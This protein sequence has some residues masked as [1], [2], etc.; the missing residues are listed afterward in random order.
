MSLLKKHWLLLTLLAIGIFVRTYDFGNI[1]PGL[2]QDEASTG[3]DAFA[4]LHFG[5]DRNG[6]ANPVMLVSWGSGMYP[7]PIYLL[8]PI[9]ALFGT[10]VFTLRLLQLLG[11]IATLLLFYDFLRRNETLYF[12]LLAL[13]LLVISPW[14]IMMSRWALDSNLL[15]FTFLAGTYCI[16]RAKQHSGWLIIASIIFALTFY[17]YGTAYVITPLFL[18]LISPYVIFSVHHK[19]KIFAISLAVFLIIA[20]PIIYYVLCNQFNLPEI[21]T[22][23]FSIPRLPG[24]ARF[25]TVSSLFHGNALR[26]IGNNF[27]NT[28]HLLINGSDGL[29]WNSFGAYGY[30]YTPA[31]FL[32]V[33]GV[34]VVLIR[35]Q[36]KQPL[37]FY[38]LL[39]LF[40]AFVLALLQPVNINRINII[41]LPLI[42]FVACGIRALSQTKEILIGFLLL[43]SVFFAHFTINYFQSYN[44]EAGGAFFASFGEAIHFAAQKTHGNIC[45]TDHVNMPYIFV[46]FYE[47]IDPKKFYETVVYKN[48]GAEFQQVLSFDRFTFGL[49]RCIDSLPEAIIATK[50]EATKIDRDV[51]DSTPFTR[52]VVGIRKNAL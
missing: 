8:I 29:I 9:F 35:R 34:L 52:Y 3:Y 7:L 45:V 37:Y 36:W 10:S 4:L 25:Q 40:S 26:E 50:Q 18:L 39:W 49:S 24:P 32:C 20:A 12:A 33:L 42:F 46:L 2:N 15:P 44:T 22:P 43:F 16:S 51:Y 14:H 38:F 17:A 5:T 19:R 23:F 41:F 6:Y 27:W 47:K 30:M 13:F 28:L 48:P 21:I 1:P 31:L 11:G